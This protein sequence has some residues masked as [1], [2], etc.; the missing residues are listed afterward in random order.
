MS[1]EDRKALKIIDSTI[2]IADG[3]YRMGL[4]W[5]QEDPYPPFNG[6][7]AESGLQA[8]KRR[9]T[10]SLVEKKDTDLP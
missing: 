3:H 6:T 4:P 8:L 7:L 2:S 1:V 10:A 9:L 5:R